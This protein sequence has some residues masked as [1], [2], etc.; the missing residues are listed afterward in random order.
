MPLSLIVIVNIA[1]SSYVRGRKNYAVYA[2]AKAAVVNF[3]QGLAE[4]R[5]D[6][7]INAIVPQRTLTPMRVDNFPDE[8]P[9]TLLNPEEVARE[10]INLLKH[11]S[12]TGTLI[13]I[14]KK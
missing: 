2:S 5:E 8:H 10:I 9:S 11:N 1:S 4:E 14:R 6:L 3:T 13:E 12:L 7:L